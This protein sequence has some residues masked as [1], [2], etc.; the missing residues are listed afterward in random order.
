M[1]AR[2]RGGGVMDGGSFTSE[3]FNR[4]AGLILSLPG[5]H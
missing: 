4:Q 1:A 3:P 2:K 5:I